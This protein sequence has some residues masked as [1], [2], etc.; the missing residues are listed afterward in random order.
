MAG[1]DAASLAQAAADQVRRLIEDA[2]TRAREIVGKAETEAAAIRDRAESQA[3][4]RLEAARRALDELGGKLGQSPPE[5]EAVEVVPDPVP[6]EPEP[7]PEPQPEPGPAAPVA[8]TAPPT[9]QDDT[10]SAKLVAL[11]MAL[12][13]VARDDAR[14][15]LASEYS[16]ADLDGLLDDVYSKAA[17]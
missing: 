11:K 6:S 3:R 5:P 16:V 1:E 17:R 8:A 4:E 2:E 7:V 9:G 14:A 10:Q 13:G 12:D 15:Q